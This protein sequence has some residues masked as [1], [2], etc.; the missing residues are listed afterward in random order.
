MAC[1]SVP[2]VPHRLTDQVQ[3]QDSSRLVGIILFIPELY[4]S[5]SWLIWRTRYYDKT[6]QAAGHRL[7]RK[8]S[9]GGEM[10]K[11][12]TP[13]PGEE[14]RYNDMFAVIIKMTEHVMTMTTTKCHRRK[15]RN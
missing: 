7:T 4:V 11:L 9:H 15:S 14:I 1:E 12:K 2:V 6:C 10:E 5:E 13:S 3:D 8:R